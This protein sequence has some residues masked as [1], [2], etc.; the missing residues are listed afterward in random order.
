MLRQLPWT[1]TWFNLPFDLCV[2]VLRDLS[3]QPIPAWVPRL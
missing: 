2:D 1:Q 3:N